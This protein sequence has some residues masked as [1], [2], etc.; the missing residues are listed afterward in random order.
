MRL[1]AAIDVVAEVMAPWLASRTESWSR[2]EARMFSDSSSSRRAV[3]V[4]RHLADGDVPSGIGG[5]SH[6]ARAHHRESGRIGGC[7]WTTATGI[8]AHA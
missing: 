5:T 7:A 3:R 1:Y 2:N 6:S 4:Q 8:F